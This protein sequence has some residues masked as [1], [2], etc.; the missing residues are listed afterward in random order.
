MQAIAT[1]IGRP[2][3]WVELSGEEAAGQLLSW[4][5]PRAT[6][7]GALRG[8]ADTVACAATPVA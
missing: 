1:A 2:V 7:E 8:W 3:K 6:V 4:G 5:W